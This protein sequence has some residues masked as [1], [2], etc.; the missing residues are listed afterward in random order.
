MR[1]PVTE[2]GS[3]SSRPSRRAVLVTGLG[4]AGALWVVGTGT[5]DAATGADGTWTRSSTQ[6][7]WKVAAGADPT[8]ETS[9]IEG[10][11]VSVALQSGAAETFLLYVARR[12]HYEIH[13]L[14][15]GDITGHTTSRKVGAAFESNYLSGTA[16]AI[17]PAL[18]P[19]GV[20]GGFFPNELVVIRDILADCEGAVRWGGDEQTVVKESHFQIDVP[21][22]DALLRK[23]AAKLDSW[24][25]TPGAGAGAIDVSQPARRKAAQA[26]QRRQAL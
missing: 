24:A 25:T 10:S 3:S 26:L 18:Y 5:A 22:D 11:N 8:I 13:S 14:S 7:G 2:S 15:T 4:L 12:F 16:V 17:R 20:K 19:A 1:E 9:R 23:L 6:N 21:P